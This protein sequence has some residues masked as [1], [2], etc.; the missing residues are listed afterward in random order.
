MAIAVIKPLPSRFKVSAEI[1]VRDWA[2][3]AVALPTTDSAVVLKLPLA[4]PSTVPLA[5]PSR[6]R[7]ERPII[8]DAKLLPPPEVNEPEVAVALALTLEASTV[9]VAWA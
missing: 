8:V 1:P 5:S 7:L 9:P 2:D 4:V 6:L 3:Q